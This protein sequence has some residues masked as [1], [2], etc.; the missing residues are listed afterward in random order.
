ME[1]Q[2]ESSYA[3]FAGE[4]KA[5]LEGIEK[6]LM[7]LS[8]QIEKKASH[9]DIKRIEEE[10]AEQCDR[11]GILEKWRWYLLGVFAVCGVLG[12]FLVPV[13]IDKVFK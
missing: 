6:M 4:V 5:K 1:D 10:V 2:T 3:Y 7:N 13:M 11:I 8:V 9:E 12:G